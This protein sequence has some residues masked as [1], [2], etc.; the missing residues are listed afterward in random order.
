M[1]RSP[2]RSRTRLLAALLLAAWALL[3]CASSGG[4]GRPAAAQGEELVFWRVDG[5]AGGQAWLLGSVHVGSPEMRYD[6]RILEAFE[7][8]D[9]LVVELDPSAIGAEETTRVVVQYGI[10]TDGRTL[11]TELS[12]ETLA[13]LWDFVDSRGRSRSEFA[14]LK[15]WFATTMVVLM[16]FSEAGYLPQ[17]GVDHHFLG[18]ARERKPVVELETL[19]FQFGLLSAQSPELQDRMLREVLESPKETAALADQVFEAWRRGDLS[20]LEAALLEARSDDP[21]LEAFSARLYDQRNEHLADR[22]DEM[23]ATRGSS[24]VVVGAGHM[25]G[26]AGIPRLLA[27]RG[28]RVA[29]IGESP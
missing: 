13:L 7:E 1:R 6:P 25:V 26:D 15:P 2:L 3:S 24:F 11:E 16:I 22:I 5:A 17:H 4:L 10:Y 14:V 21:D 20:E 19:E 8:A 12:P 23:L 18:L 27:R 29:R 28:H 9:R